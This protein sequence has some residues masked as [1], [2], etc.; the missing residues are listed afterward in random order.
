MTT[1]FF[2]RHAQPD[3]SWE[4][5][6]SRPLTDE[7]KVDSEKLINY[8]K[9]KNIHLFISSPYVRS[10][11]TIA[12]AAKYYSQEIITDERL[13]ER[14]AGK[15]SNRIELFNKRWEE[16]SYAEDDGECLDSVQ[17]RNMS[18]VHEILKNHM[19]KNIVIGT[20]GTAFSTIMNYYDRSFG[21]REFLRIINFMPYVVRLI[22]NGNTLVSKSEEFVEEKTYSG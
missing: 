13:R 8:F 21:C 14:K 17:R 20:H 22:F 2:V 9:D 3:H 7:G 6:R 16:K 12:P 19:N 1:L 11:G 5:D 18:A 15:G 10:I 4:D